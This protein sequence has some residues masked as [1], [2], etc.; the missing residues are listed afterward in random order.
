MDEHKNGTVLLLEE[1]DTELIKKNITQ[2]DRLMLKSMRY[3][4]EEVP[5][6][7]ANISKLNGEVAILEKNNIVLQA[8]KHP[9][10]AALFMI[11]LLTVN[12]MINWAGIRRPILQGIIHVTT[13][14][15]VPLD[16]L[17]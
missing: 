5:I 10:G 9:K 12:S 15:V 1:I 3:I 14:I 11:G 6:T 17:P 13:G 4:L 7:R 2:R 16:S 8:K